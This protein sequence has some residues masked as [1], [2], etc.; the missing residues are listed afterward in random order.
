MCL[1]R[2]DELPENTQN[3]KKMSIWRI[4]KVDVLY[5]KI[6]L[7]SI[8]YSNEFSSVT[9]ICRSQTFGESFQFQVYLSNLSIDSE[10]HSVKF[11]KAV[12]N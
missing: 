8:Y 2:E 11:K 1:N 6:M 5:I 4:I 12:L 10:C 7:I 3:Y 9:F